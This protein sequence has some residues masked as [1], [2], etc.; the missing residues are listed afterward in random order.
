MNGNGFT[1]TVIGGGPGA[2]YQVRLNNGQTVNA[3]V[4]YIDSTENVPNGG[5]YLC[6]Q[7]SGTYYFFPPI[8]QPAS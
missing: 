4:P 3:T 2:L 5:V 1:A 8:F 7:I 6:I